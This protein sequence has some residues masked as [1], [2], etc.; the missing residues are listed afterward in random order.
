MAHCLLLPMLTS[1]SWVADLFIFSAILNSV[2]ITALESVLVCFSVVVINTMTK[3]NKQKTQTQNKTKKPWG[4]EG[5]YFSLHFHIIVHFLG[6][7]G[8]G[9]SSRNSGGMLLTDSFSGLLSHLSYIAQPHLLGI[10]LHPVGWTFLQP[11]SV[12]TASHRHGHMT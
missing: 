7:W 5:F 12:N 6:V 4:G 1:N 8:K 3:T 11:L 9:S 10:I 2:N